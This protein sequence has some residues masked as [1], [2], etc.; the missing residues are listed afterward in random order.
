VIDQ[1]A[2]YWK[3]DRDGGVMHDTSPRNNHLTH[4]SSVASASSRHT[5]L[6]DFGHVLLNSNEFLYID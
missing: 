1:V 3:F 5:A 4:Q 2:A 6:V